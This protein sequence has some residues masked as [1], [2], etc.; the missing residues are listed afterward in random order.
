[1]PSASAK[2]CFVAGNA[3]RTPGARVVRRTLPLLSSEARVSADQRL[4][5][6]RDGGCRT[7]PR[8]P[9]WVCSKGGVGKPEGRCLAAARSALPRRCEPPQR[10]LQRAQ[11]R[12]SQMALCDSLDGTQSSVPALTLRL[13]SAEQR[14]RPRPICSRTCE[15]DHKQIARATPSRPAWRC[16]P[17]GCPKP[18][19][20]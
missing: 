14:T 11:P 20:A 2:T 6:A 1:V 12:F 16:D 4:T 3:S 15:R 7:P 9:H 10:P 17:R 13:L 8:R 19:L 5:L 18:R